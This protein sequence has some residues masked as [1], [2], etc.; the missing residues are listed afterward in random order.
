MSPCLSIVRVLAWPPSKPSCMSVVRVRATSSTPRRRGAALVVALAGVL[1]LHRR[2]A[3]VEHRLAVHHHLHLA[4]DAA[5]AAQQDVLGLVVV[6]R[7]PPRLR[8]VVLVV[9]RAHQQ[10]VAHDHPAGRRTPAGL[11]DHRAGQVAHVGGHAHVDRRHPEGA[12]ATAQDR[13]E[14]AGGVEARD[15]HPVDRARGRDQ[16]G[17]LAVAEE[18][19]LADRHGPGLVD[20]RAQAVAGVL[21]LRHAARIDPV[22]EPV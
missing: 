12:G 16:G 11:E 15:A 17:D 6:G 9:P 8:A 20:D 7:A 22:G 10:H 19:V 14:D 21:L 13:A 5:D 1:P 2:A 3:V 18:P 4:G